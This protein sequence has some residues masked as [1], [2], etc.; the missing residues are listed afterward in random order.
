L[1]DQARDDI[2]RA[3]GSDQHDEAHRH[4]LWALAADVTTLTVNFFNTIDP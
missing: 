4:L 3:A 2:E 1:A